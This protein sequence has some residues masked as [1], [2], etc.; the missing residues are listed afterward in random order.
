[1]GRAPTTGLVTVTDTLPE[2]LTFV[3]G[4][5]PGWECSAVGNVVTC[6]TSLPIPPVGS[7]DIVIQVAVAPSLG[8]RRVRNVAEVAAGGDINEANN[9]DDDDGPVEPA[10]GSPTP[11][12]TEAA[13]TPTPAPT[14]PPPQ[15]LDVA[16]TKALT[17]PS[18][19]VVPGSV[20][21]FRI[22]VRNRGPNAT[23][24]PLTVTDNL[25]G[26]LAYEGMTAGPAGAA[27][28]GI[29]DRWVCPAP[30]PDPVG[31]ALVCTNAAVL[32]V[33]QRTEFLIRVRVLL[34]ASG[35]SL[36]NRATVDTVGDTIAANNTDTARVFVLGPINTPPPDGDVRPPDCP[37]G[38]LSGWMAPSQ[39][40]WQDD[41]NF[42]DRPD[43]QLVQLSPT[44]YRA[45]L[46]MVI[47]RPT[48]LFGIRGSADALN[49][50]K[51]NRIVIQGT[52]TGTVPVPVKLQ[53]SLV[54]DE[55]HHHIWTS[56]VVATPRLDGPCGTPTSFTAE[57]NTRQGIPP[58]PNQAFTIGAIGSS[59]SY[60]LYARLVRADETSTGIAVTVDG[61]AQGVPAP[62]VRFVPLVLSEAATENGTMHRQGQRDPATTFADEAQALREDAEAIARDARNWIPDYFP[63][64]PGGLLTDVDY[65]HDLSLTARD[66]SPAELIAALVKRFGTA[67]ALAQ[68]GRQRSS[69]IHR[70]G[71]AWRSRTRRRSSVTS[72]STTRSVTNWSTSCRTS[73]P[74][75]R[76]R[77]NAPI[78]ATTGTDRMGGA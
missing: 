27:Q 49:D 41:Y 71:R 63:L 24:G 58:A 21:T 46:K 1:M 5:G 6:R 17:G 57:V 8:G 76:W 22:S 31:Q 16:L 65:L 68:V 60:R 11:V 19:T 7:V 36:I 25:P 45:E 70:P 18:D 55:G 4:S 44:A 51:R 12:P 14:Q 64:P 73:G 52:A 30:A 20:V 39:G 9:R 74:T 2:G 34:R 56:P 38:D 3:S 29:D 23:R 10:N 62:R 67:A 40:V 37:P 13:I 69:R 28:G 35:T 72:S 77:R 26:V 42:E 53:F 66:K 32:G 43:K 78:P 33:D 54:D 61:L 75:S 50:P 59:G 15:D 48:L 47:G